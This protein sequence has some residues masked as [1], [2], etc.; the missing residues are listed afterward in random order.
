MNNGCSTQGGSVLRTPDS[1]TFQ[2]AVLRSSS[3]DSD[4]LLQVSLTV[5]PLALPGGNGPAFYIAV[6]PAFTFSEFDS[7]GG[8]GFAFDVFCVTLLF[9]PSQSLSFWIASIAMC[10]I[11]FWL[12]MD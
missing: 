5:S 3:I 4:E 12:K 11:I 2:N 6:G 8:L 1:Y 7:F 10:C 9:R